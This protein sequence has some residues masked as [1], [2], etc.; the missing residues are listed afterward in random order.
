MR[1]KKIGA[2]LCASAVLTASAL[3]WAGE[4][5]TVDGL[6]IPDG[7]VL[8][9]MGAVD[10]N[11]GPVYRQCVDGTLG[12]PF[13]AS[14]LPRSAAV[15]PEQAQAQAVAPAPVPP[16]G[17]G[18]AATVGAGD[19]DAAVRRLLTEQPGLV[20]AAMQR[21]QEQ[22][23]QQVAAERNRKLAEMLPK[24]VE[25]G[26][27]VGPVEAD[28][29]VVEWLDYGCPYCQQSEPGVRELLAKDPKVRV[30][31]KEMPILGPSSVL[32]ARV[33]LAAREQG[34]YLD[35]HQALM[36]MK[37][38]HGV[39]LKPAMIEEM[40]ATL[41]LDGERLKRDMESPEVNRA[42]AETRAEAASLGIQSTPTFAIGAEVVPMA[43]TAEGLAAK[44]AEVRSKVQASAATP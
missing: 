24:V 38:G 4:I 17:Q 19:L 27:S 9:Q 10:M 23:R 22:Q 6:G 20:A 21:A 43:L 29:T 37:T 3:S 2:M 28:V 33:A 16:A 26:I 12:A 7:T 31:F 34:R 25:S 39:D 18:R 14:S 11:G 41:G 42:L 44:V 5:C 15:A 36:E 1:T 30:V 13:T 35:V 40:V 8:L 32:A